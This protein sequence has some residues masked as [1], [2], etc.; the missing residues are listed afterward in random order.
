MNKELY[1]EQQPRYLEYLAFLYFLSSIFF[2]GA[3]IPFHRMMWATLLCGGLLALPFLY[4]VHKLIHRYGI[5]KPLL[6]LT[7]VIA[8]LFA[9]LTLYCLSEFLFSCVLQELPVWLFPAAFLLCCIYAAV[10]DIH[11]LERFSKLCGPVVLLLLFLAVCSGIAK[12]RLSFTYGFFSWRDYTATSAGAFFSGVLFFAV[13]FFSEG[14]VLL[15]ILNQK[16]KTPAIFKDAAIG[17]LLSIVFLS[18]AYLVT[19]LALGPDVFELLTYPVYYPPGLTGNAEYL[20]RIEV[21]LLAVFI[22]SEFVKT[23]VCL[24]MIKESLLV[25]LGKTGSFSAD[26]GTKTEKTKSAAKRAG[27]APKSKAGGSAAS[28][29]EAEIKAAK[30]KVPSPIE[31]A[32]MEFGADMI[33][34]NGVFPLSVSPVDDKMSAAMPARADAAISDLAKPP[35]ADSIKN[36]CRAR[37]NKPDMTSPNSVSLLS[38]GVSESGRISGGPAANRPSTEQPEASK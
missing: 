16:R 34:I 10:K 29:S 28:L 27:S 30:I 15:T 31:L 1:E 13:L 5:G 32:S 3:L 8:A 24:M 35:A 4:G 33:G 38:S 26:S 12:V 14:I 36:V 18:A 9:A 23:A 6:A 2:L 17:F 7:A 25:I 22:L 21:I 37:T 11:V 20:E 19:V